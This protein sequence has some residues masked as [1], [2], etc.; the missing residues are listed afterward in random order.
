MSSE[1]DIRYDLLI[2]SRVSVENSKAN[3]PGFGYAN[4]PQ[5]ADMSIRP[6]SKVTEL[7]EIGADTKQPEAHCF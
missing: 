2:A 6:P 7:T 1:L 4:E 5:P 3:F